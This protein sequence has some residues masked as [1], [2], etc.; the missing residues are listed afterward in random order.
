MNSV[1]SLIEEK[2]QSL[3]KGNVEAIYAFRHPYGCSQ[4]GDDQENTRE[5]LADLINHPNAG[6]VLVLGLGCENSNIDVL[7]PYI[8]ND[9][10]RIKYL[11]AQEYDDEVSKA[12]ELRVSYKMC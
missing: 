6:G 4:M 11:V 10:D 2:A 5:I 12:L 3:I 9:S 7:K 8:N 1:A